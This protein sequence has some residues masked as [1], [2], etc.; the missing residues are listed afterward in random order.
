MSKDGEFKK[1]VLSDGLRVLTEKM[2][3]V[4]SVSLGVWIATGSRDERDGEG[5]LSHVIEHMVFKGTDKR[6]SKEIASS[7]ESLGGSLDAFT[8]KE[9][10]CY[11]ARLLDEHLPIAVEVLSDI[12]RGS[13][14]DP[15]ELEKEKGVIL[16]EIKSFEDSPDELALDLLFKAVFRKHPLS[17]P[18]LGLA[19]TVKGFSRED[20]KAYLTDRYTSDRM[21]VSA[22]GNVNH[23]ALSDL[24]E[25]C[26]DFPLSDSKLEDPEL[27]ESKSRF[28]LRK[29]KDI[30]QVHA[31]IG[32]RTFEYGHADRYALLVL[33]TILGGGMS[34]RL[35]QKLREEEGL[36]YSVFS[37]PELYRDCGILGVYFASDPQNFPKSVRMVFSEFQ[38]LTKDGLL[39]DELKDAKSHLKG[40]LMISLESTSNRM[41]RLAKGEIYLRRY[42]TLNE[43][44]RE[45]EGVEAEDVMRVAGA[46]LSPESQSLGVV[47]PLKRKVDLKDLLP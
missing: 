13:L 30:S 38:R 20:V 25:S 42:S 44:V 1:S 10:T 15:A 36:V 46:L 3:Q 27:P 47:G 4:R 31:C 19:R 8:S 14:F 26:F 16:E 17:R 32:C 6:T 34:S 9:V 45:I 40:G 11:Y 29:R 28:E 21:I 2:K 39:G 22:A 23:S 5:G 24:C 7:L 35:F 33:N 37:Y 43:I 41:M 12:L 18:V